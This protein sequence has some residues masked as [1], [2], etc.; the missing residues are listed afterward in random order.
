MASANTMETFNCSAEQFFNIVADF[1]K[2][3]EFLPEVKSV[4]IYKSTSEYKEM[5]Y[6]VSLLKTFKYKL[7]V[8]E[9][10]PSSV[11]FEFI[12]GDVFKTMKGS[13]SIEPKGEQCQVKYQVDATF[14]LLVPGPVANG[15]VSVNLPL[16]INNFKARVKKIYGK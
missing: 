4:K 1:E 5:E 10:K 12:G 7:K 15:L 13:W 2:Y 8:T 14:G 9:V 11:K 16:M 6:H 3:P